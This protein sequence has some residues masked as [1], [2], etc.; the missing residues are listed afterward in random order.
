MI[1]NKE[2]KFSENNKTIYGILYLIICKQFL[3][4]V[5]DE[6]LSAKVAEQGVERNTT[7]C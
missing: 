1:I 6:L 5:R 7:I 4:F 3:T 2:Q